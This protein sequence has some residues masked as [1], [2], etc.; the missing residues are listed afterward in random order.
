[1]AI[2]KLT[3]YD[4]GY[5]AGDLSVYKSAI[6]NYETLYEAKNLA[7]SKTLQFISVSDQLIVCPEPAHAQAIGRFLTGCTFNSP[8]KSP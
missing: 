3:S 7:S 6:D 8:G 1:M 2:E 5:V 4:S